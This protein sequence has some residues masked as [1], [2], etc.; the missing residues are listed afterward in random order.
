MDIKSPDVMELVFHLGAQV[1][2]QRSIFDPAYDMEMVSKHVI[3]IREDVVSAN[4]SAM[5]NGK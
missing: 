5:H 1:D 4:L 3:Y 2:V